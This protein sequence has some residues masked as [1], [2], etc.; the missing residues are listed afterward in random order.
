M[1]IDIRGHAYTGPQVLA[2]FHADNR[3]TYR[4]V[5]I[6][7]EDTPPTYSAV[8]RS[9]GNGYTLAQSSRSYA[10]GGAYLGFY[11]GAFVTPAGSPF[12]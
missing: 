7:L 3:T 12:K 10:Y 4:A 2:G 5:V 11:A 8:V 1:S 9:L 6:I